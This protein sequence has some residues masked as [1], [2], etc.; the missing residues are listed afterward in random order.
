MSTITIA[1]LVLPRVREGALTALLDCAEAIDQAGRDPGEHQRIRERLQATWRLL[2]EIRWNS[3]DD[4]PGVG[5]QI[6]TD[7]HRQALF[8]ATQI[9]LPLLD[10]WLQELPAGDPRRPGRQAELNA[11]RK[12]HTGLCGQAGERQ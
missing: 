2:D 4:R 5:A 1:P 3:E 7:E 8:A 10:G 12:L 11:T 6:D 9:M